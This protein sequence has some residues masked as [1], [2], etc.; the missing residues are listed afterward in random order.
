VIALEREG[1]SLVIAVIAENAKEK[2]PAE[3]RQALE[4]VRTLR[5]RPP[6]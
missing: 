1:T 3:V 2:A 5:T 6:G 4:T